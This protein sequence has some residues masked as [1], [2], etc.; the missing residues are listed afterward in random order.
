MISYAVLSWLPSR[1][2]VKRREKVGALT[3]RAVLSILPA[4]LVFLGVWRI[5]YKT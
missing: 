3:S 4:G 2:W 5:N 1:R